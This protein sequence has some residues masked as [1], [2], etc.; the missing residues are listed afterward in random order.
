MKHLLLVTLALFALVP[1][2]AQAP[3]MHTDALG[4]TYT[5]PEDWQIVAPK[6]SAQP[7]Q[8]GQPAPDELRKGIFCVDV[9]LTATHGSPATVIVI[10]TL[11]F[12]CFGQTMTRQDLPGFGIGV[13]EGIKRTF[14]ILNPVQATYTLAGHPMW[15]QRVKATPQG[16]SAPVFTIETTCTLLEK[17]AVCWMALASDEAG[18]SE[19]EH[20]KVALEGSTASLLVP[21]STFLKAP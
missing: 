5:L 19:F 9:P 12:G 21:A 6:P 17:G 2:A 14:D 18:L 10:V 1:L 4:F 7:P 15:I 11:P 20:S 8:S 13:S 3:Q 16:K